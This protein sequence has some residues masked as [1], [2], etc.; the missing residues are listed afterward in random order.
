[1]K[2]QFLKYILGYTFTFK[3]CAKNVREKTTKCS[4]K[5]DIYQ[6]AVAPNC[7]KNHKLLI[8]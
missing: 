8:T 4:V 1:M 7:F 3:A 6:S 2:N 5:T